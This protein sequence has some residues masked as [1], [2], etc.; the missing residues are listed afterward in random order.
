V[1]LTG[2]GFFWGLNRCG[3]GFQL[4]DAGL[5]LEL[6]RTGVRRVVNCFGVVFLT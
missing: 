1:Q 5:C 2:A 4:K 6:N 3:W